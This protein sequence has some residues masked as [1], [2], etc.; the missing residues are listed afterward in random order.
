MA[1]VMTI[2]RQLY[3]IQRKEKE[4]KEKPEGKTVT[5]MLDDVSLYE[6]IKNICMAADLKYRIEEYAVVIAHKNFPMDPVKTKIYPVP[7]E[8]FNELRNRMK[9]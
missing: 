3:G 1:I 5:I 2:Q 8:V 9:K 6:A 4:I 7:P